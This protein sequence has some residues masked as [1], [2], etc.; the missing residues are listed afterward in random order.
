MITNSKVW[1]DDY[2][3]IITLGRWL[4]EKKDF[5]AEQILRFF[6]K[7]WKWSDEY[8]EMRSDNG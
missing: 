3:N 4:V 8:K 7:P 5:T 6:E 1:H 2:D